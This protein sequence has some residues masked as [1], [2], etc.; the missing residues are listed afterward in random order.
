MNNK[1]IDSNI[2]FNYDTNIKFK[3]FIYYRQTEGI[4]DG[5]YIF[6]GE[7]TLNDFDYIRAQRVNG[8]VTNF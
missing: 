3:V 5:L 7:C 8:I 1:Y 2:H 6:Y 4:T